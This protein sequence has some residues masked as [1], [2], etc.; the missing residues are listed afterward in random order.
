MNTHTE[1]CVFAKS[2][3]ALFMVAALILA[4]ASSWATAQVAEGSQNPQNT[5]VE[6]IRVQSRL[7][8]NAILITEL[9]VVFVYEAELV[10]QMPN[11]KRAWYSNKRN[12]TRSAAEGLDV[13]NLFIPQ[14]FDS[15]TLTL[16]ERRGQALKV[17]VYA[18][19]DSADAAPADITEAEEV[20]IEI[21]PFGI[22]VTQ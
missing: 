2:R 14:G 4:G 15:D 11:T 20:F 9:D 12:F 8:P 3:H 6:S 10:A 1:H 5:R 16:P 21:D 18:Y 7:D 17:L 19:H 22:R 13:V